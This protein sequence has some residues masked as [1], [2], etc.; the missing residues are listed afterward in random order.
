MEGG[1]VKKSVTK[2]NIVLI[3]MPGSGKSHFGRI[4]S[5]RTGRPFFDTDEM[6]F[7]IYGIKPEDYIKNEGEESF[8]DAE[9]K[10]ISTLADKEGA[11]ISAGGGAGLRL[12]N[13]G[14]LKKNAVCIWVKRPI[15][16]L[17][18]EN[19]PISE[20][21]GLLTL[22]GER[23]GIYESMADF[24]LNNDKNADFALSIILANLTH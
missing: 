12:E 5:E 8:R 9:C 18:T 7:E 24:E 15:S 13:R 21:N 1:T 2:K 6:F 3:G 19:R 23:A 22:Y 14:V 17:S 10:V 11:V 4:I 16:E 20:E